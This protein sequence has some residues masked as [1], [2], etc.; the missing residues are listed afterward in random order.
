MILFSTG[1]NCATSLVIFCSLGFAGI[2]IFTL[3]SGMVFTVSV[4]FT[5]YWFRQPEQKMFRYLAH[6]RAKGTKKV[7][8]KEVSVYL[9]KRLTRGDIKQL[10]NQLGEAKGY[11]LDGNKILLEEPSKK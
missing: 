8:L 2:L 7:S 10:I 1:L 9:N 11:K 6:L 5:V 3:S 4:F